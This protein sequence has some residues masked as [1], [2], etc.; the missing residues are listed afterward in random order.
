VCIGRRFAIL[1]ML[2][3]LTLLLRRYTFTVDPSHKVLDVSHITLAPKYGIKLF[4]T[5]RG[6]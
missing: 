6:D 2:V 5:P 4:L 3:T 1:E